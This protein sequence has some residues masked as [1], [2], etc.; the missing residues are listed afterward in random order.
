MSLKEVNDWYVPSVIDCEF[1]PPS[2]VSEYGKYSRA[3]DSPPSIES[4]DLLPVEMTKT[5]FRLSCISTP[6][7]KEEPY[8]THEST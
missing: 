5:R 8:E 4:T 7:E 6:V 2:E 1:S 3:D